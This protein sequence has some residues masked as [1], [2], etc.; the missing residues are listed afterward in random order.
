MKDLRWMSAETHEKFNDIVLRGIYADRGM[1]GFG[2]VL[3]EQAASDIH[4][5]LIA[6]AT[7]DYA[8]A[9]HP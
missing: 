5:Y 7:E 3:S 1:I 8:D 6:R 4:A 9:G 2:D